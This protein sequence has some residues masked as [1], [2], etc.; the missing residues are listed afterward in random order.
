MPDPLAAGAHIMTMSTY[1]SLGGPPAGLLVT[2]DDEIA[3]RVDAIAFP[4]LTA[5][6]DVA[7]TA[8]LALTLL[9]WRT[10]GTDYA[11]AMCENALRLA[12]ELVERGYLVRKPV[13]VEGDC[14]AGIGIQGLDSA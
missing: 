6:F 2:N 3:R 12:E 14:Q 7:Q 8:A 11:T 5:N 10:H 13:P 9:D 4:G 1:K